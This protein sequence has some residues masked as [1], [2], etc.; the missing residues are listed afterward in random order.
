MWREFEYIGANVSSRFGNFGSPCFFKGVCC[1]YKGVSHQVLAVKW[2]NISQLLQCFE[3]WGKE[4]RNLYSFSGTIVLTALMQRLRDLHETDFWLNRAVAPASSVHKTV[5][6][7]ATGNY[8]T[9]WL[10]D[11]DPP[12]EVVASLLQGRK[13]RVLVSK[14]SRKD[15]QLSSVKKL[16]NFGTNIKGVIFKLFRGL[17][18]LSAFFLILPYVL[19]R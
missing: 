14:G 12:K 10:R 7:V 11:D 15:A 6:L 18:T 16:N 5:L 13:S 2:T 4:V 3:N 8:L 17:E 1:F 9:R 19:R